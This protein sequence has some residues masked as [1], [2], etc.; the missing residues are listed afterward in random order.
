MYCTAH[1]GSDTN[2]SVTGFFFRTAL[3]NQFLCTGQS[4]VTE[5]VNNFGQHLARQVSVGFCI[6]PAD[7]VEPVMNLRDEEF[8]GQLFIQEPTTAILEA[9]RDKSDLALWSD[10]SRLESGKVGAAVVWRDAPADRWKS[11]KLAL[12]KN[13]EV[14]DAELWGVSEALGVALRKTA[15]RKPYKVT[16]FSDS[17]TAIR[18]IQGSKTGPGQALK[19]QIVKRAKQ[20]QSRG[21]EVTI[22]W[23]PSHSKIEGNEQ[24]DKAAKEAATGGKI[25][26]AQWSSLAYIN[27][28]I[29]EA[30]KSEIWSWHRAKNEE[31]ESRNRSYYVPRL[32]PGIHHVLGQ[33]PK[34]YA[35]RFFQL[36][37]GHAATGVFLERIGK[38]E[39]ADC[40]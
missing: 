11:C 19:A 8:L 40:L 27:R 9:Q 5:K 26:T 38:R 29:T 34:K 13:K 24:A 2:F 18:K 36:R 33:A 25:G 17:Q 31:R 7:G 10:G 28:S 37:V 22:R 6:D 15:P 23:V 39:T 12:G 16:V 20:L 21:S 4:R 35:A 30:K 3:G 32:K 1:A 14:L